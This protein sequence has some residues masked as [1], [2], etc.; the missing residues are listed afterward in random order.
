[1]STALDSPPAAS[2]LRARTRAAGTA[3]LIGAGG[4]IITL[5]LNAIL[6]AAQ[7]GPDYPTPLEAQDFFGYNAFS[8]VSLTLLWSVGFLVA[9]VGIGRVTLARDTV[10]ATV[11]RWLGGLGAGAIA[12]SAGNLF[13][14]AGGAATQISETGADKAAQRGIFEG[15]FVTTNAMSFAAMIL[16]AGWIVVSAVI[17]RRAGAHGTALV[18]VGIVAGI[19]IVALC[20]A[21]GF[22]VGS[23]VITPYFIVV[24]IVYLIRARRLPNTA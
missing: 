11:G 22:P 20:I 17:G 9:V 1:M 5:P 8:W 2:A 14:Q 13:S 19:L 12:L 24:G 15:T 10:A 18:I 21:T 3:S 4:F 6:S 23:L 7:D 16:L